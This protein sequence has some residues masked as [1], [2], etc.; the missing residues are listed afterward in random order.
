MNISVER[1][2][3]LP[4]MGRDRRIHQAE[5]F[6]LIWKGNEQ[7]DCSLESRHFAYIPYFVPRSMRQVGKHFFFLTV[8]KIESYS[9]GR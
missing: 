2:W 4:E 8:V 1:I 7:I 9:F 3:P 5:G 6:A